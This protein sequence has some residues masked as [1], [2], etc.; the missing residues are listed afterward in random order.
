VEECGKRIG[1][2]SGLA[3]ELQAFQADRV[4]NDR[5]P[6]PLRACSACAG[7]YEDP[8]RTAGMFDEA[9]DEGS[10]GSHDT[11]AEEFPADDH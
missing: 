11:S 8:D 5:A 1:R 10:D 4:E 7:D 9:D 6:G 3:P 2:K